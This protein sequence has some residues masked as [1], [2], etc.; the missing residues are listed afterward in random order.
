MLVALE[1]LS[2][3]TRLL[4]A[5][6]VVA[7]LLVVVGGLGYWGSLAQST[8]AT[9]RTQLDR[10][11][12][13]VDLIRYYDADVA[14]W[15]VAVAL[16]AHNAS[17]RPVTAKDPNRVAEMADKAALVRLL[18]RF[19]VG[20]L[21]AAE[22]PRFR[23][24]IRD[25][26][27]FWR[28][29]SQLFGLYLK[30]DARSVAAA[31]AITNGASTNAFAALSNETLAL[32]DAVDARSVKLAAGDTSTGASVRLLILA[33]TVLALAL[34]VAAALLVTRT[35]IRPTRQLMRRLERLNREDLEALSTGLRSVA[36]GDLTVAASPA[37]E[38]IP[39]PR[40][41]EIGA[42]SR[43]ANSVIA[44]VR[45]SLEDY[46]TA[47]ASLSEMISQLSSTAGV[48]ATT[49]DQLA[50]SSQE[51]GHANH[52]IN[53]AMDEVA[54]GAAR[55]AS[56]MEQTRRTAGGLATGVRESSRHARELAEAA[57]QTRTVAA[58]GVQAAEQ[59]SQSMLAVRDSSR[60]VTAGIRRLAD[61][62]QRISA[63]TDTIHELSEQT[64]LLAL[65]AAIEAARAG[66]QGRGFAVVAEEVRR[67][68]DGSR[69]AAEEIGQLIGTIQ[70]ETT[71][72]VGLVDEAAE[73]SHAG[74]E[75][76]E[77]TRSAFL[78]ID[79]AIDRIAARIRE[80]AEAADAAATESTAMQTSIESVSALAEASSAATE[81]VSASTEQTTAS[82]EQI[83]AS[84]QELAETAQRLNRLAT[85]F[86]PVAER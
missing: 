49:S 77:E 23:A 61:E 5:F 53:R 22:R 6:G 2:L 20:D 56:E 32:S 47:R 44:T 3:R 73:R 60:S 58:H 38:P 30:G 46:N 36:E 48:L 13:E 42:A 17:G 25:W 83:A 54:E 8:S 28:L 4:G 55:Q 64:N 85:R 27:W 41:D 10:V 9:N 43:S 76:V 35:I 52:E 14:G 62:S 86:K 11:V 29:D 68:A 78:E 26:A 65:N 15:Q 74:V 19:P 84:A 24:I 7:A 1:N 12:R 37:T 79:A 18:P 51:A 82:S 31:D 69:R 50:A 16:D 45:S 71:N 63:I 39:N 33:G 34:A 40:R 81:E 80:V 66:E 72:V 21:T 67:L 59:V 75:V 57:T 70:G